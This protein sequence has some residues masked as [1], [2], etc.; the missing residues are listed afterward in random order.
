MDTTNIVGTTALASSV[1]VLGKQ[2]WYGEMCIKKKVM[3]FCKRYL[4][5]VIFL[6][7]WALLLSYLRVGSSDNL[8]FSLYIFFSHCLTNTSIQTH[9]QTHIQTQAYK[10]KHTS[11]RAYTIIYTLINFRRFFSFSSCFVVVGMKRGAGGGCGGGCGGGEE[12]KFV[13]CNLYILNGGFRT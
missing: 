1:D 5:I 13:L 2:Y 9:I 3:C 12:W 8:T 4:S 11:I 7:F 10:H 6:L